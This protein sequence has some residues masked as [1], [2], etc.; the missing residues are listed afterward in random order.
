M[1]IEVS[2]LS[3]VYQGG[4][5]LASEA[6]RNVSLRV[7]DH[8]F[9]GL[10]GHTGSGKSTLVQHLNGLIRPV[11]GRVVVD[12]VSLGEKGVD[13]KQIRRKVGLVFQFPEYQLFEETVAEDIAF[14]PRNMGLGESEV[15]SRV[16]QAM[17]LVDLDYEEL[18]GRSP[19]ELSGGQK[20]RVALA[21]V[22]AM[23][24]KYLILDEPTAGLDP[25]GRRQLLDLIRRM[26]T[27]ER[28]SIV[29]VTHNMEEVAQLA[30]KVAVM[31]KGT[32]ALEGAPAEVF[33]QADVLR[34][35][36]LDLP[37]ITDL[38]YRLKSRGW[39]L[40]PAAFTIHE[41]ALRIA[42]SLSK[43]A[44][45]GRGRSAVRNHGHSF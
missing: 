42:S 34:R 39:D 29:Y 22:L 4:T 14:G 38:L 35:V 31:Y 36:G 43:A 8:D 45:P 1:P 25:R 27:A 40:D 16:R 21:G 18:A 12:G 17:T 10:I 26:H 44:E 2:N 30:R 9:V 15:D 28:V 19:F 3:Y 13:L 6:L 24:P 33:G 32:I 11:T 5:P 7:E 37:A 41:A 20:R 23:R